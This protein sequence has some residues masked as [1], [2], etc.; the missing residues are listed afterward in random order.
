MGQAIALD[1]A[2]VGQDLVERGLADRLGE[3][4]RSRT[5]E[6]ALDRIIDRSPGK[7]YEAAA[8]LRVVFANGPM[9][10]YAVDVGHRQI[11]EDQVYDLSG[12]EL[13]ERLA[14][15]VRTDNVVATHAAQIARE[16]FQEKRLVV[17]Q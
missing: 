10:F 6:V 3:D 14:S 15:A 13:S 12:L 11:A 5:L 9:D 7:K 16:R 1:A 17:Y 4:Q 2:Y 8:Q